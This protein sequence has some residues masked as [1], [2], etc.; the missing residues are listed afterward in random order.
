MKTSIFYF[1]LVA[2]LTISLDRVYTFCSDKLLSLSKNRF[3]KM[4]QGRNQG[5]I[6]ILGNSRADRHFDPIWIEEKTDKTTVNLG[7]GGNH[8]K[9][10]SI[11]LKD[12]LSIYPA[13]SILIVEVTSTSVPP[14]SMGDFLLFTP[15]SSNLQ[16]LLQSSSPEYFW[17]TRLFKSLAYNNDMFFR[18]LKDI[19]HNKE[20]RYLN[21][22]MSKN[23]KENYFSSM[24][25]HNDNLAALE[26]II[27][28]STK[29]SINT[30]FVIAPI[31]VD[32]NK[33]NGYQKWKNSIEKIISKS[34]YKLIDHANMINK[35]N[36]FNDPQHLNKEGATL[37]QEKLF[38][39]LI[40]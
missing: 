20:N 26:E 12:F 23:D 37:W 24:E 39:E 8:M 1:L 36:L 25:L 31:G 5:E 28:I 38:T 22:E 35:I 9:L 2:I 14:N 29:N 16:A 32:S 6:L 17:G 18:V 34:P 19:I 4:Y 11:L 15:Y 40:Q 10:N 13:P 3:V 27:D 21:G 7:I 33:L 30:Y